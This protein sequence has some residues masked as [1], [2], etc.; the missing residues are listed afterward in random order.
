VDTVNVPFNYLIEECGVVPQRIYGRLD[1]AV[2]RTKPY[3]TT[4]VMNGRQT[5]YQNQSLRLSV[6]GFASDDVW[7]AGMEGKIFHYD[8]IEF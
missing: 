7:I 1:L 6:Y 5:V 8:G 2:G 4:M 3:G